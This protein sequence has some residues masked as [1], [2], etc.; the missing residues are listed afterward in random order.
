MKY[1]YAICPKCNNSSVILNSDI[2]AKCF[3][4]NHIFPNPNFIS[5]K[6]STCNM[7]YIEEKYPFISTMEKYP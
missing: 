2:Q 3:Y 5:W 4:C 1:L 7:T 6:N